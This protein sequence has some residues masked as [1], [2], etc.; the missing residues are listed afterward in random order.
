HLYRLLLPASSGHPAHRRRNRDAATAAALDQRG[1]AG[2]GGRNRG[3]QRGESVVI[4]ITGRKAATT[5][6]LLLAATMGAG[7][8]AWAAD[9]EH[10]E[11]ERQD[12]SF[13]GLLGHYDRA[14]LQRGF[15]VYK[16]V[17]STCH[18]LKRLAFRNLVQ[19][20]GPEF[21]EAGV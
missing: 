6:A 15:K 17:C 2:Q 12:W 5:A 8:L 21:P 9:G 3:R 7:A 14:Q 10:A 13:S 20:G 11:V 18:G 16:D 19:P 1:G 4:A